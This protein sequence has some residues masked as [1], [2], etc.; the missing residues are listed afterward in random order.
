M[1]KNYL[2][3]HYLNQHYSQG[4]SPSYFMNSA[5]D[6]FGHQYEF[7]KLYREDS[8]YGLMSQAEYEYDA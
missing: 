1:S 4:Y 2:N 5:S 6:P 8:R 7:E 3:Y